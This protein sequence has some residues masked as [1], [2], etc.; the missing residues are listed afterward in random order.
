[1]TEKHIA[2]AKITIR[3]Q[4]TIPK[5]VQNILGG[6]EKGDFLLFYEDRDRVYIK[7]GVVTPISK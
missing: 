6:M 1:M 5:K 3:K 7:R 2:M 4:I